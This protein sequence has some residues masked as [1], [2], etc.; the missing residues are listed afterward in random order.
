MF[1]NLLIFFCFKQELFEFH[2]FIV[3]I[4]YFIPSLV[5]P[6]PFIPLIYYIVGHSIIQIIL[7]V[8]DRQIKLNLL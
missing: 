1:R 5:L 2:V 7:K 4:K 8:I 3:K 6:K